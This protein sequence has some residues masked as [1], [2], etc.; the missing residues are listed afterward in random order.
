[1]LRKIMAL[2][3][4]TVILMA[5]CIIPTSAESISDHLFFNVDF[6]TGSA[7]DATG[8]YALNVDISGADLV[9][10]DDA[11]LGRKVAL[12]EDAGNMIWENKNG[13]DFSGYDLTN[14]FTMEM[15]LYVIPEA[16]EYQQ[17]QTFFE[18][19]FGSIHLQEYNDGSDKSMGFRCVSGTDADGNFDMCNAYS[20]ELLPRK[21]WVH[22]IG[23]SDGEYN[24]FY[25]NGQRVATSTQR[26]TKTAD[27]RYPQ[28]SNQVLIGESTYGSMFSATT[29]NAKIAFARM[30]KTHVID[31]E[32]AALYEDAKNGTTPVGPTAD[33]SKPTEAPDP[34]KPTEA[35]ATEQPTAAPA[36][37][38]QPP[39]DAENAKTFDVGL[40]ALAAVSLS[41]LV[42][43]RRK[44]G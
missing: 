30:Y 15:Y 43:V 19:N 2:T 33:P 16:S 10:E 34:S 27:T 36:T 44:K 11:T 26:P 41:S 35:P 12:F 13:F 39:K 40:V 18:C 32:A 7:E 21:Q 25:L 17:N 5:M 23:T 3:I 37:P 4:A 29:I 20:T 28:K 6:N 9:L 24:Y 31:A 8:N 42:V 1:M 38:T 22:I 14:G